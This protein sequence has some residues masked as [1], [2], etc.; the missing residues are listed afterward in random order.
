MPYVMQ[1]CMLLPLIILHLKHVHLG[2]QKAVSLKGRTTHICSFGCGFA[3]AT[4]MGCAGSELSFGIII[5]L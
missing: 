4:K 1:V 5:V 3:C 2:L